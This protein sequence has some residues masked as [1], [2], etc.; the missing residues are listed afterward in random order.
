MIWHALHDIR[1]AAVAARG[2]KALRLVA[3]RER[4]VPTAGVGA[5]RR[6]HSAERHFVVIG[7]WV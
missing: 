5:A 4:P 1:P 2:K 6:C 3:R 7:H